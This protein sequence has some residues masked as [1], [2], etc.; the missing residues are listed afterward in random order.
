M[1]I[2]S[3]RP[4]TTTGSLRMTVALSTASH[5]AGRFSGD[6]VVA[7]RAATSSMPTAGASTQ[8]DGRDR[9]YPAR[10]DVL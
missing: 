9:R 8:V 1:A 7:G 10:S 5:G 3:F 4:S 6:G 2:R